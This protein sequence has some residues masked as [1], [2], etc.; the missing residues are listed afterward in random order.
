MHASVVVVVAVVAVVGAREITLPHNH[1]SQ[2]LHKV[3]DG[4]VWNSVLNVLQHFEDNLPKIKEN[5]TF[6]LLRLLGITDER[7]LRDYKYLKTRVQ[8]AATELTSEE[9]VRLENAVTNILQMINDDNVNLHSCLEDLHTVK[10]VLNPHLDET[11]QQSLD[12]LE[13][14]IIRITKFFRMV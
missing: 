10:T 6:T 3:K 12:S 4:N 11:Y 5:F 13:K 8:E 1:T 2:L 14:M 9:K 7:I